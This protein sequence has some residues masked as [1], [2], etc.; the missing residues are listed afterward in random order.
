MANKSERTYACPA[1]CT[2]RIHI[3]FRGR[4]CY[5]E[6]HTWPSGLRCSKSGK[7]VLFPTRYLGR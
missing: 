7:K 5:W 2:A 6:E 4:D 1:G 3:E